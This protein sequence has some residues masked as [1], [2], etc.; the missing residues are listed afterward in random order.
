MA[1]KTLDLTAKGGIVVDDELVDR[2]DDDAQR[3]HFHGKGGKV[4]SRFSARIPTAGTKPVHAC[5][6]LAV[7]SDVEIVDRQ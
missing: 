7:A 4:T 3:G 1:N 2:W 5:L 6:G